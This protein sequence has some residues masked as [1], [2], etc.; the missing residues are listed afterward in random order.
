M[1]RNS[2]LFLGIRYRVWSRSLLSIVLAVISGGLISPLSSQTESTAATGAKLFQMRCFVC[3]G[4]DGKGNGPSSNDLAEKPPDFTDP[5][6]QRTIP[7]D[8]LRK[9]IQGG[10]TALARSDAMPPNPDLTADQISALTAYIRSLG[11]QS[12]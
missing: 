9:V 10:S 1:V 3:H 8:Q 12:Q 7:D 6:W 11:H 2:P 4:R 5:N